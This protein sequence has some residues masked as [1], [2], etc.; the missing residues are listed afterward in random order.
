MQERQ[1]LI[2]NSNRLAS[3]AA[4]QPEQIAKR[5]DKVADEYG[6]EDDLE[7]FGPLV[8][9]LANRVRAKEWKKLVRH[10]AALL[11][12]LLLAVPAVAAQHPILCGPVSAVSDGDTIKVGKVRVR[13]HGIDAPETAQECALA[14]GKPYRCGVDATNALREL[15]G[16][17]AVFCAVLDVDR[18]GRL[19]GR[20]L[21]NS[22]SGP[23]LSRLMV[24]QG[25]A[26]AYR[27]YSTDYVNTEA[28]AQAARLGI[29]RGSFQ[30]PEDFRKENKR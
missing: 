12:A 28:R 5:L 24:Q 19:I 17:Q 7:G 6:G 29:W 2:R 13:L 26:V 27:K 9:D 25:W 16:G 23:D 4:E 14:D 21:L 8:A 11:L 30:L 20:C 1:R 18:Y 22:T 15:V 3:E 10:A